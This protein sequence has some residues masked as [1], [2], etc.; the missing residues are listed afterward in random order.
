MTGEQLKELRN[1][2]INFIK[3]GTSW[4]VEFF[5]IFDLDPTFIDDTDTNWDSGTLINM[6]TQG[7]G[8]S[9]NLT[10]SGRNVSG[11]FGSQVFDAGAG[12]TANWT[13]ISVITEVPYGVELG[14]AFND[15]NTVSVATQNNF[16]FINGKIK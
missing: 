13:N 11:S 2:N 10:S 3:Q 15:S 14:R 12:N 4:I 6:V 16:G 8:A 7:T 9:A 5:N 1:I